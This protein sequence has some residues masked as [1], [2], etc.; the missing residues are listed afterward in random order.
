[1]LAQVKNNLA[2]PQPS[3]SFSLQP[4]A[5]G[6]TDLCWLGESLLTADELLAARRQGL[7]SG[8]RRDAARDF[9]ADFLRAGPRTSREIWLAALPLGLSKRTLFRA[10]RELAVRVETIWE[11][12]QKRNY[13]LLPHQQLPKGDPAAAGSADLEPWLAPLREQFPPLTP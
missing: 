1:V 8:I 13:W 5:D 11:G 7:P 9:L 2:P 10:R 6:G 4:R 12:I 3:L